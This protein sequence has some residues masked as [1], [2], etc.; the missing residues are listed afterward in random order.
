MRTRHIQS[1]ILLTAL[2]LT[3]SGCPGQDTVWRSVLYPEA[4]T[5]AFTDAQG[6]F[7]H[8]FSYAGYKYGED[9]P[10]AKAGPVIDVVTDHG[11]DNAGAADA[12]AAIQAAID[13]AEVAG[14]VVFF[15][16]GM[17]RI[18]G[19]LTV[20]ASNVILRGDTAPP[21]RLR[22]TKVDGMTGKAHIT[23]RGSVGQSGDIPLAQDG[24]NRSFT[25]RVADASGLS[26]GDEVALGWVITDEFIAEHNMT[27]TWQAFNGTWRPIFRRTV[28]STDTG[29]TPHT[30]TLDV[31]LRYPAKVRDSASLRTQ[32]GYI[33]ECGIENLEVTSAVDWNAAWSEERVHTFTMQGV[34][35]C[36][37]RD[38][39][40]FETPDRHGYH[41]QNCGVRILD[42]KRVTV[43]DCRLE[44]AQNRG[45]G[46]CGYLFEISRSNEILTRDCV[47]RHGRHNFI[48]NWDFGATGCVWLRCVSSGSLNVVSSAFPIGLPAYC[49]YHHSLAMGCLVDQCSF[50]DGWYG[51]NRHD[52]SSGAGLTCTQ[53]V[54][55]NTDGGGRIRSWQYGLGYIVGTESITLETSMLD[56][57]ADGS[58]PKDYVEGEDR[59]SGLRPV[60]LYED[61]RVRRV[62]P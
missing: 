38:V 3:A 25:V 52:W 4:W 18:E 28:I 57:S 19:Q 54:Y 26:A 48:Q 23:I 35:D 14:G 61:Q 51:G 42:C 55:W 9:L 59:G 24:E 44:R 41:L 58:E 62:G 47:A 46:G 29:T 50:A 16:G 13:A 34:K 60:S 21:A 7:L 15:P 45:S 56:P 31:P 53:S 10:G 30:V 8:D 40:S 37:M 32:T 39:R 27:G 12:T 33:S 20:T 49:E 43:A 1:V 11:A 36:W 2:L 5:P 6:R 22:F 17:Y